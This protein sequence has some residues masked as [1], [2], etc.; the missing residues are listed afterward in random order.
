MTVELQHGSEVQHPI[1]SLNGHIVLLNH[2]PLSPLD[3]G[4][5]FGRRRIRD[6]EKL[7]AVLYGT[8]TGIWTV[9][10]IIFHWV[11]NHR[12]SRTQAVDRPSHRKDRIIRQLQSTDNSDAWYHAG[13]RAGKR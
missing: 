13:T 8:W 4:F 9:Y 7:S 12:T 2:L 11:R 10:R 1:I 5:T 3:R 6:H